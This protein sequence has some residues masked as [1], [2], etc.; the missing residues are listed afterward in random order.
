MSVLYYK[1]ID[2]K[3]QSLNPYLLGRFIYH[4]L[5]CSLLGF[6][7]PVVFN[8]GILIPI[9]VIHRVLNHVKA[10]ILTEA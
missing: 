10:E 2:R 1:Q 7:F 3:K 8:V 9:L 5:S 6:C 4:K